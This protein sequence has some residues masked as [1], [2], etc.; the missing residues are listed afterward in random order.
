MKKRFIKRDREAAHNRLYKDYFA[1]DALYN[2]QHFRRRFRMRRHLFLRI[3]EALGHHSEYFQLMYD[4][5]GKHGLSPLTKCTAAMRMLAYGVAADCVD[6]YLKIGASTAM[7]CL[8]QFALGVVQ[9]FGEEYLRKPNQADVDRLLQVA[10]ARD[11]PGMLGSIDCMHW[12]WKNCPTAWKT[13]FQKQIYKVPT[14][15]LEAVASYDLWIWHAF[16]GLPGSLNDINVLDR[17]P[18]FQELY[19]DRVPKCEYVVNGHQYNIGYYLSDGI[20]PKWATFVKTIPLPQGPKR[21]L[22]AERQESVRKDVERAFGVLQARF[23]IVRGPARLMDQNE[24]GTIMRACVILH[25]MIV[26]DE[27]DNYELAFD[28]D[29]VDGTVPEPLVNHNHHPCYETY[30]QRS[31]EV[32]NSATHAALQADLVEEIWKRNSDRHR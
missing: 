10:E 9:V 17:S 31:C 24:I 18:V 5:I 4:A 2:A 22:F 19:D 12:E 13:S 29:V 30:F 11:F 6:E 7:E 23:A 26:E 25:N 8:K 32:R 16:F 3:V 20:Y 21:K 1:E 14:I 28:Y 27:R 15:I